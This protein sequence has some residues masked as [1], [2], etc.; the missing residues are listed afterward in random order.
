MLTE[1]AVDKL[2]VLIETHAGPDKDELTAALE[3][4][5]RLIGTQALIMR[6]M[7]R[8][9]TN[10]RVGAR[11]INTIADQSTLEG[12]LSNLDPPK[13]N[14]FTMGEVRAACDQLVTKVNAATD[15]TEI[16]K[17]VVQV[18]KVFI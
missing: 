3:D 13:R 16:L 7:R 11:S 6:N 15:F 12:L 2:N 10:A 9:L 5:C 1:A 18:A 4:I 17:G 14:P 8:K